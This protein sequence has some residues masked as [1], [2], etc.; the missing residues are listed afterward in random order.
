MTEA[1]TIREARAR[2]EADAAKA[3][4]METFEELKARAA[5]KRVVGDAVDAAKERASLAA[6]E[7]RDKAV[8]TAH[9]VKDR[10]VA[11]AYAA[12]DKT[13]ELAEDTVTVVKDRPVLAAGLVGALGLFL[14]R[15]PIIA[16]VKGLF[17]DEDR[18]PWPKWDGPWP[19]AEAAPPEAEDYLP[20]TSDSTAPPEAVAGKEMM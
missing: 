18:D 14:A 20:E 16:A 6:G 12:R 8:A 3:R 15:K 7:A 10:T 19:E 5:P 11:T 17:D 13:A 9:A 2:G 4:L 1:F